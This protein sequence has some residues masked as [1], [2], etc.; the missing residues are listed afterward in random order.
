MNSGISRNFRKTIKHRIKKMRKTFF[1]IITIL[2]VSCNKTDST[3]QN[4]TTNSENEL[5]VNEAT[6]VAD[7]V[8]NAIDYLANVEVNG[9]NPKIIEAIKILEEA[10]SY[11]KKGILKQMDNAEVNSKINPL[12]KR[13]EELKKDLS[14]SEIEQL[15]NYRITEINKLIDLQA[16]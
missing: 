16:Q 2:L 5:S 10:N 8:A 14:A 6:R 7:S 1:L 11:V 9:E 15:E 3:K 4:S 13:Y 12:M